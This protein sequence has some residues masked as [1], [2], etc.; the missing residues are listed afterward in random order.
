MVGDALERLRGLMPFLE[1]GTFRSRISPGISHD[2]FCSRV[3]S[4]YLHETRYK[5]AAFASLPFNVCRTSYALFQFCCA[6]FISG[7]CPA[8]W[9]IPNHKSTLLHITSH[10]SLTITTVTTDSIRCSML[11]ITALYLGH[12]GLGLAFQMQVKAFPSS[13]LTASMPLND[14]L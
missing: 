11:M 3:H 1:P 8:F 9:Q 13:A 14:N 5:V 12:S 7:L 2:F 6:P 10:L 4:E